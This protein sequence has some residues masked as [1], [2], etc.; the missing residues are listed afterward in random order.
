[1]I[2]WNIQGNAVVLYN[3]PRPYTYYPTRDGFTPIDTI[4]VFIPNNR[5][6][7]DNLFVNLKMSKKLTLDSEGRYVLTVYFDARNLLNKLN[8]R[9][10]DSSGKIGGELGDPGAY[11]D[12]RR[13]RIGARIDF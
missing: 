12:P 3:S 4:H 1:M 7:S 6:M 10:M 2:P 5:R 13:I 8:V 9:W 11:Y